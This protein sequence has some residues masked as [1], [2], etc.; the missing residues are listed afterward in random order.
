MAAWMVSPE[1][2]Q[3]GDKGGAHCQ[4][5]IAVIPNGVPEETQDEKTQDTDPR[6]LR[7]VAKEQ[8]W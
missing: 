6:E 4:A 1:R 3:R 5:C 8:F 2:T 7:Y